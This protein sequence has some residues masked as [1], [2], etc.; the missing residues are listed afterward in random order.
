MHLYEFILYGDGGLYNEGGL[1]KVE[2]YIAA[3]SQDYLAFRIFH[4]VGIHGNGDGKHFRFWAVLIDMDR[5]QAVGQALWIEG[6]NLYVVRD[7]SDI[8][9][10]G[11]KTI[12]F[13]KV[14]ENRVKD[15]S[16]TVVLAHREELLTPQGSM[17]LYG[18]LRLR[19]GDF[20]GFLNGIDYNEFNPENDKNLAEEYFSKKQ[21]NSLKMQ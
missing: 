6:S 3:V 16:H 1:F 4:A 20:C 19:E 5:E 8:F 15:G 11:G 17:G 14:I 12:V 13:S 7:H 10:G 21:R 18:D 9:T 2:H